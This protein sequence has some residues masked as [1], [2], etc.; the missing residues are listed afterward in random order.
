MKLTDIIKL[1]SWAAVFVISA[2]TIPV[3]FV[4][5]QSI[6]EVS[7]GNALEALT[8]VIEGEFE[9][10]LADRFERFM[11]VEE[12]ESLS[13]ALNSPGGNLI[14]GIKLGLLFRKY[15]LWTSIAKQLPYNGYFAEFDD[16]AIC[17]SACAVAFLGGK[18]RFLGNDLQLG[19][20]QFY[21]S[22]TTGNFI[23]EIEDER[24][25]SGNSQMMSA[26]LVSYLSELGDVDLR[27]MLLAASTPPEAM[28]WVSR[29]EAVELKIIKNDD[30]WSTFW[31]EPYGKGVIAASRR[32]DAKDGYDSLHPYDLVAQ[33][34]AFCRESKKFFMLSTPYKPDVKASDFNVEWSF[35][36]QNRRR[37]DIIEPGAFEVRGSNSQGWFDVP[38]TDSV[39][40]H[41][42]QS[43]EFRL[44]IP[45]PR[46]VGGNYAFS[47]KLTEQDR[48]MID[49]AFRLCIS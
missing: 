45:L 46:V 14:E 20:H 34:T 12:P 3:Q 24:I 8:I 28:Y 4:Q 2:V 22:K 25:V 21:T 43:D 31:L 36:D 5:A 9:P 38:V 7:S 32:K 18:L 41:I 16:S 10:G 29:K 6:R 26:L 11:E 39:A 40:K 1:Y 37:I 15:G 47:I 33:A 17:T 42:Q 27:L 44:L 49:A 13:V 35:W 23:K 30:G 19:L 48:R